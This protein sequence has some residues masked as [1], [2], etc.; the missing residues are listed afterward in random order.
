MEHP[1][2]EVTYRRPKT[3]S[4]RT[5]IV[6]FQDG[7]DVS[8]LPTAY[9]SAAVTNA[10]GLSSTEKMDT[11]VKVRPT[12][13]LIA[14]DTYRPTAQAKLLALQ[15]ITMEDG[16]HPVRTYLAAPGTTSKGSYME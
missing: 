9:V 15:E 10:A 8:K 3:A 5:V 16:S 4:S 13:N 12:Q 7:T 6:K 2:T 11:Y 14:A 1:W